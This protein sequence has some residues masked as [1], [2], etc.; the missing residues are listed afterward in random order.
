MIAPA[1]VVD[2]RSAPELAPHDDGNRLAQPALAEIFVRRP[3]MSLSSQTASYA[4]VVERT[5]AAVGAWYE[6]F[7]RSEGA[8]RLKDG[9][10]RS[11]TFRTAAKS[12]PR[13]LA[14]RLP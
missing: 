12:L 11:G 9:T 4:I 13:L 7:P 5:T 14:V 6:F 1:G 10:L 3:I 2:A 8:R